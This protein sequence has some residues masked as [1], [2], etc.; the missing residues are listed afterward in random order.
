MLV[1]SSI[2]KITPLFFLLLLWFTRDRSRGLYFWSTIV[3]FVL[4]FAVSYLSSPVLFVHFLKNAVALDERGSINNCSLAFIKDFLSA[5]RERMG[6]P[7][8][9]QIDIIIFFAFALTILIISWKAIKTLMSKPIPQKIIWLLFF[10]CLIYTMIV[11]R[12]KNYSYILLIVPS[13]FIIKNI[14]HT[15]LSFLLFLLPLLSVNNPY[16]VFPAFALGLLWDYFPWIV[17]FIFW[18]MYINEI[19]LFVHGK[20]SKEQQCLEDS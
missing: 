10:M 7:L 11:P 15:K 6:I 13:Y 4:I 17:A 9:S 3:C 18:L 14:R 2:F 12:F 8:P 19:S 20:M 1:I 5:V 16:T